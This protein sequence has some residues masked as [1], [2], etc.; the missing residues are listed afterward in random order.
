MNSP[1]NMFDALG[2]AA[3]R[4][5]SYENLTDCQNLEAAIAKMTGMIDKAIP[6]MSDI[7]QMF[8]SAKN[9]QIVAGIG[10]LSY[11]FVGGYTMYDELAAYEA[12]TFKV[13]AGGLGGAASGGAF[14]V[15]ADEATLRIP[16]A[17][18]KGI[19]HLNLLNLAETAAEQ[20][21]EIAENM[22]A[23]TYETIRGLQVQL[24]NMMNMYQ[25][26]C[27]CKK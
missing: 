14:T 1:L 15:I 12:A 27:P 24:A 13:G 26:N 7:N 16:N 21:E 3:F 20:D 4:L 17:L 2:L 10:E 19:S 6:S 9:M 22:S 25:Q 23:S 8:N 11:A 18:P 5:L